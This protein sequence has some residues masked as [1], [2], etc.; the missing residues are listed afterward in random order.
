[1]KKLLISTVILLIAGTS[2][3]SQSIWKMTYDVAIP[4]SS[5]KDYTDHFSWRGASLDGDRMLDSN[6]G[7]GFGFSWQT[8]VEKE[9]DTQ[10]EYNNSLVTG[11]Q[12]RYVNTIPMFARLSYYNEMDLFTPYFTAGIGTAWQEKR[13]DIGVWSITESAWHFALAPEIGIIVPAGPTFVTFKVKYMQAF[14]TSSTDALTYL[15]FGL[16]LAW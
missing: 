8:F 3:F 6:L 2:L 7:I 13:T 9:V 12:V 10:L 14:K 4:F 16:G 1:M 11:T 5:T 15:N